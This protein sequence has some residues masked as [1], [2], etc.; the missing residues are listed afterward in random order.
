MKVRKVKILS[1]PYGGLYG[2]VK[3]YDSFIRTITTLSVNEKFEIFEMMPFL[4]VKTL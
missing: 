4:N 3:Y 2:Y 1:G